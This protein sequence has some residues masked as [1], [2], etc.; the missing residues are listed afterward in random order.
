[1][2]V[3]INLTEWVWHENELMEMDGP[4]TKHREM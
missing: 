2:L 1:M 4:A 3:I